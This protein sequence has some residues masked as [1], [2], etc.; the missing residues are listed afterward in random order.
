MVSV[1]GCFYGFRRWTFG[2][3]C[4]R[5]RIQDFRMY[6]AIP[7]LFMFLGLVSIAGFFKWFSSWQENVVLW[8][9]SL[10]SFMVSVV[11]R[12]VFFWFPSLVF[13]MF[14]G[15][16]RTAAVSPMETVKKKKE[17][18]T[19]SLFAWRTKY[20]YICIYTYIHIYFYPPGPGGAEG[21]PRR[22]PTNNINYNNNN[23]N[24]NDNNIITIKSNNDYINWYRTITFTIILNYTILNINEYWT[25]KL[26]M[27]TL[28]I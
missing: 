18:K 13:C 28:I 24:N 6:R 26:T 22:P 10:V 9:P 27:V 3:F 14:S 25:I 16:Y 5:R 8:F 7:C 20:I 1:V 4:L 17:N 12:N 21:R 19:I 23:N 11:A 15:S 2:G